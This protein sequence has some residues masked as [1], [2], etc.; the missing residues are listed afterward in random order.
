MTEFGAIVDIAQAFNAANRVRKEVGNMVGE[1][2]SRNGHREGVPDDVARA[3]RRKEAS[4]SRKGNAAEADADFSSTNAEGFVANPSES[5]ALASY[6]LAKDY[7]SELGKQ[8]AL[9]DYRQRI[10]GSAWLQF[11][12]GVRGA[13][14]SHESLRAFRALVPVPT[15][16]LEAILNSEITAIAKMQ[17]HVKQAIGNWQAVV[18]QLQAYD[19]AIIGEFAEAKNSFLSSNVTIGAAQ[20]DM[21][22]LEG[23]LGRTPMEAADYVGKKV[24]LDS[25]KREKRT[26]GHMQEEA[27]QM[28]VYTVKQ[29]EVVQAKEEMVEKGLH[30][31]R[32]V[33]DYFGTFLNFVQNT[34]AADSVIPKLA[35]TMQLVSDCYRTLSTVLEGRNAETTAAAENLASG[36]KSISYK[37]FPNA[38]TEAQK[39]KSIMEK[40]DNA[41]NFTEQAWKLLRG[42]GYDAANSANGAGQREAAPT[43]A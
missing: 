2:E 8:Q 23:L 29:S 6:R 28:L 13:V 30:V 1:F 24:R 20:K 11:A 25:L 7:M 16:E 36:A 38:H 19:A 32:L 4:R 9:A 27:A 42:N 35:E 3:I 26:A 12:E 40:A 14:H 5:K 15:P 34:R 43:A 41:T 39:Q 37:V 22:E 10:E 17:K 18:N 33:N 21:V 31:F